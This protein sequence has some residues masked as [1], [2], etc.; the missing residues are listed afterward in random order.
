MYEEFWTD[1]GVIRTFYYPLFLARRLAYAIVQ[2]FL[3]SCPELQAYINV[4]FSLVML[5]YL[6]WFKVFRNV[7]ILI[8]QIVA[9]ICIFVVFSASSLFLYTENESYIKIIENICIYSTLG[10][11]GIQFAVS[12]ILFI[13]DIIKLWN[14]LIKARSL[15]FIKK[16]KSLR[17]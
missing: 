7:F 15:L 14:E 8:S 17:Y 1:K 5:I 13:K 12:M 4:G 3:N 6:M 16:A 9:E 11:I 2:I 10:T